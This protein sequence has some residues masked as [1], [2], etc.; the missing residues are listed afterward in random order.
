MI[1][2]HALYAQNSNA[3]KES[4]TENLKELTNNIFKYP[5]FVKGKIISRDSSAID[6]KLNYDR[7]LG[8]ILYIDRI[9]KAVPLENLETIEK[10]IIAT[11]T[12]NLYNNNFMKKIQFENNNK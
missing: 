7:V 8:K 6:A 5:A 11:D 4:S 2:K 12:F 9:G 1:C 3:T 10:V